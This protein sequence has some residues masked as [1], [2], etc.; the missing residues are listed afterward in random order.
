M[1]TD[2]QIAEMSAAQHAEVARRLVAKNMTV[3]A[4][5]GQRPRSLF[6]TIV[7]GASIA[8]IPWIVFLAISLPKTYIVRRWTGVWT[9][10]DI[11]LLLT[12]LASLWA[13]WNRRQVLIIFAIMGATLLTCD[14][15]FDVM[16]A[17]S[18]SDEL[19]SVASAL[20]GELPFAALLLMTA[21]RLLRLTMQRAREHAGVE[22]ELPPLYKVGLLG[23]GHWET[24]L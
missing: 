19:V 15:W 23:L 7:I 11:V 10:F 22:G 21:R 13:A 14:A 18:R 24:N 2:Q 5:M 16:T 20:F 8:L 6:L 1:L 3:P 12:I 4:S 17:S 9:G